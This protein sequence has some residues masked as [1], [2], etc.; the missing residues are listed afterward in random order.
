MPSYSTVTAS[1]RLMMALF[2]AGVI[3]AVLILGVSFSPPTPTEIRHALE[4]VLVNRPAQ[5]APEQADF[6]AQSNQLGSGI[7]EETSK[8]SPQKIPLSGQQ[9][10]TSKAAAVPEIQATQVHSKQILTQKQAKQV[11]PIASTDSP[12]PE[13]II[14]PKVTVAS[15]ANQLQKIGNELIRQRQEYAKR[16]KIMYINS[17]R[18]RM[19]VA[20]AYEQAWQDKIERLGNLNYPDEAIRKELSGTLVLAVGINKDGSLYKIEVRKSSGHQVLDDAAK[21]IVKLATPFSKF[22]QQLSNEADVLVITRTWRF[23]EDYQMAT[24]Y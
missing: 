22:P 17:V 19:Y 1:D 24:T 23:S 16:P 13:A 15:L 14:R 20:A 21:R 2:F 7:N 3:H 8:P 9:K 11:T 6:H 18:A 10:S 12:K 5:E 4:I